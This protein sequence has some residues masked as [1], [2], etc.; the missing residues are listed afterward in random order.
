MDRAVAV[1][2]FPFY[3]SI[4]VVTN[5]AELVS[6]ALLLVDPDSHQ[7]GNLLSTYALTLYRE[8]GNYEVAEDAL[9]RASS[10]ELRLLR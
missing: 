1:A 10:A 9:T 2:E 7:A 6:R 3:V 8:T 5:H 4:G